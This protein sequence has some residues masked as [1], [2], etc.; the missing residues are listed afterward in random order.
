MDG[1]KIKQITSQSRRDFTAVYE[2]EHCGHSDTGS[3][4]DDDNFHRNVIPNMACKK[5]GKK[6]AGDYRPMGTKYPEGMQ[7]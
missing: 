4:Y 1:M 7:V 3:G 6:A 2:C 5:C